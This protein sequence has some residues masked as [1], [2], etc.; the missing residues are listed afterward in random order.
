MKLGAKKITA[1]DLDLEARGGQV[2][3]D[4]RAEV[5]ARMPDGRDGTVGVD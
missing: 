2:A 3:S 1:A 4:L 5:E